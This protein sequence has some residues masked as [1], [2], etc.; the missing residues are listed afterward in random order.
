MA[1][2]K[3]EPVQA[4][5]ALSKAR[6]KLMLLRDSV[7]F[8]T[9]ILQAQV[10]WI[11]A[12]EVE[13]IQTDGV[14]LFINPDWFVSL[15]P[16]ERLFI[17][18]HEVMHVVYNHNLRMGTRDKKMW[19]DA[20]DY[21][22]NSDLVQR[23]YT[24]PEICIHDHQFDDMSADEVYEILLAMPPQGGGGSGD[25]G[26]GDGKSNKPQGGQGNNMPDLQEPPPPQNS[27]GDG[28][29]DGN[30]QPQKGTGG[31]DRPTQ[32]QIEETAKDMLTGAVQQAEMAGNSAGSIPGNL[33]RQLDEMLNPKLPWT[34]I[35][36]KFLFSMS[37]DDYSWRKPNRRYMSQGIIMP[38]L[39][40]EG[41]GRIDFAIDTSGSVSK[42]DFDRFI[43]EIG[44]VFKTF[45]PKEIGIMQFD[46]VLQ[47]NDKV[48]D[49]KDFMKLEFK[50]GGGTN[51]TP[52]LEEFTK[53][54][55]KALIMLTDGYFHHS[56]TQDPKKPVVWCIYNNPHFKPEFGTAI[57]FDN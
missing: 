15:S 29:G 24:R 39:H 9:L 4:V 31:V 57:H 2:V 33:V 40:S 38:S 49:L 53:N 55:A 47:G 43:S 22:I 30:Q 42:A 32:A 50:G 28:E 25:N 37:K 14:N 18:I 46:H 20:C 12:D 19:Q 5:E 26:Q 7:F 1:I 21:S 11:T 51:I 56:A 36:A 16:D 52:V 45:N 10:H 35:L 23:G 17:L 48:C 6:V 8:S 54:D 3:P 13:T 34:K 44:Y 27:Q 41:I